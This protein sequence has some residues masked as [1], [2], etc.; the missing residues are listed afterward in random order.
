VSYDELA[1]QRAFPPLQKVLLDGT[2][3]G[4]VVAS[5]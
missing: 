4:Q 3:M 2:V 1:A 5:V